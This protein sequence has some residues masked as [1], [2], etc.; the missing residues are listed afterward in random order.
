M[1]K[2][3]SFCTPFLPTPVCGEC[4]GVGDTEVRA[5]SF[6]TQ[7]QMAWILKDLHVWLDLDPHTLLYLSLHCQQLLFPVVN[8]DLCT[9]LTQGVHHH[10]PGR[11]GIQADNLRTEGE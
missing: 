7:I 3:V 1:Q 5:V 9:S 6:L 2:L 11:A 4:G 10:P 8:L